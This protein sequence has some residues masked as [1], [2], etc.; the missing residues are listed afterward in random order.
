MI[1]SGP[2]SCIVQDIECLIDWNEV[3]LVTSTKL[4]NMDEKL[5]TDDWVP[6]EWTDKV[7]VYYDCVLSSAEWQ[8]R[9]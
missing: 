9:P 8:N 3:P 7:T 1:A 2:V 4:V 5:Y 6:G